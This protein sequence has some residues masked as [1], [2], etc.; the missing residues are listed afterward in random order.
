MADRRM[1]AKTIIDSDAFLDMP[2]A[3]QL[4]Y[5]H[6]CMRA[7]DDGYLNN[8]LSIIKCIGLTKLDIQPLLNR[9]YIKQFGTG[10]QILDWEVATGKAENARKRNTYKYRK[11]RDSVLKRDGHKC[12]KCGSEDKLNVH[13]IKQFSLYKELR[14]D[15]ENAITLCEKC[16]KKIHREERLDG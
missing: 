9:E 11:W 16:H 3:S 10:Y 12:Q 1:F 7:D 4:L 14:H 2:V 5:F 15:S 13:H 6:L 8:A